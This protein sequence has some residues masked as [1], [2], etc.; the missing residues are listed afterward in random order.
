MGTA[1]GQQ[2]RGM[3]E[4]LE[5]ITSVLDGGE[6]AEYAM[7][8]RSRGHK[9]GADYGATRAGPML[10]QIAKTPSGE[11]RARWAD[12]VDDGNP[13]VVFEP[14]QLKSTAEGQQHRGMFEELESITSV[15]DGGEF[16]ECAMS[17]RS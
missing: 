11:Q 7:S 15:L 5:S 17:P 2:H 14:H 3:F 12:I 13:I 6:F 8:P 1:E 4:E 16:A 10:Q 9:D